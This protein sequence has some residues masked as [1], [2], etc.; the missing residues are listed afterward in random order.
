M[1][2]GRLA[3]EESDVYMELIDEARIA[4]IQRASDV[5]I[6]VREVEDGHRRRCVRVVGDGRAESKCESKSSRRGSHM[7]R[8][9]NLICTHMHIH[10]SGCA[11]RRVVEHAVREVE[12][13]SV[14]GEERSEECQRIDEHVE[15]NSRTTQNTALSRTDGRVKTV[16]ESRPKT[17][18]RKQAIVT[19]K[20]G[21]QISDS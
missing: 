17:C 4:L 18:D 10:V 8:Q 13:R 5:R 11:R 7:R 20:K 1:L 2:H 19:I 16:H 15:Y 12:V 3:V 6:V 14:R 21:R 9:V